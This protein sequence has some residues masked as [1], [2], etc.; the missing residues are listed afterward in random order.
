M[1]TTVTLALVRGVQAT[2][3]HVGD[4]RAYLVDSH[5]ERIIQVTDDHSFVEALVAAGHLTHE[6]AEEHP[7]RNVLYRAL[8]QGEDIDIDV[9]EVRLRANDRLVLCSDGLTRHVKA[10]EIAE[11]VLINRAPEIASQTL[12]DLANARGGE[13][14]VS[15]IIILVEKDIPDDR[16][17]AEDS[18]I[19]LKPIT[20]PEEETLLLKDKHYI[21]ALSD[22][23]DTLKATD[24]LDAP[25]PAQTV[26]TGETGGEGRD[27]RTPL[28]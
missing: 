9:Y 3:A 27:P 4:S 22:A 14:N 18:T 8:G 24:V 5:N 21:E 16:A 7:M 28:Q 6:Q 15:V 11:V 10:Q 13:D 19:E 17:R 1:G 20:I 12:I 26:N 2:I 23:E 25:R